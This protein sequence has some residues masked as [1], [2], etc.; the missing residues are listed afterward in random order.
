MTQMWISEEEC[1]QTFGSKCPSRYDSLSLS[2]TIIFINVRAQ[3]R[4]HTLTLSITQT[5]KVTRTHTTRTQ[6]AHKTHTQTYLFFLFLLRGDKNITL[7][8]EDL[9]VESMFLDKTI[10]YP[11]MFPT[12]ES[13]R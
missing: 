4:T 12:N 2:C 5:H 9:I 1:I 8:F 3:T 7:S 6:H 11:D 13:S 10:Y